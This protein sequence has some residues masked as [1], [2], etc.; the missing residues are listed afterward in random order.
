MED[1]DIMASPITTV[2]QN[3]LTTLKLEDLDELN[4][5]TS[6]DFLLYKNPAYQPSTFNQ[7]KE[8]QKYQPERQRTYEY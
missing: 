8:D 1:G 3:D 2:N 6:K 4:R 5:R 7:R